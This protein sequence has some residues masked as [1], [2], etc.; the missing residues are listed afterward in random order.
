ML[1]TSESSIE[2]EH[3]SR[4]VRPGYGNGF[5]VLSEH[6]IITYIIK[7]RQTTETW[8]VCELPELYPTWEVFGHGERE[9]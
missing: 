4:A 1:S 7:R 2:A 3:R 6:L 8:M 5:L 9:T